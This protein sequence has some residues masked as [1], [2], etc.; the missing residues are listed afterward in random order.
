M[1]LVGRYYRISLIWSITI[2]THSQI[3]HCRS[4]GLEKCYKCNTGS[5]HFTFFFLNW[6]TFHKEI[7][8]AY[9]K[10]NF[11]VYRDWVKLTASL[12]LSVCLSQHLLTIS[13]WCR[14]LVP[15]PKINC[16]NITSHGW[17]FRAWTTPT[18]QGNNSIQLVLK[19]PTPPPEFY[20]CNTIR[21]YN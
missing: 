14:L 4:I 13:L 7:F 11:T 8:Q 21:K 3:L 19:P 17:V 5:S 12:S 9:V 15:P 2:L 1:I 18:Y 20:H 6:K 16:W 10:Y